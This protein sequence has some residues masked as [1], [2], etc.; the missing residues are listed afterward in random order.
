MKEKLKNAV[1]KVKTHLKENKELYIVGGCVLTA[2]AI[3][4]TTLSKHVSVSP[5]AIVIGGN[6]VVDQSTVINVVRNGHP[7]KALL[8]PMTGV[9][10]PSINS[11]AKAFDVS[12][13]TIRARISDG[14]LLHLGDALPA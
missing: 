1:T 10:Y 11:A 9:Q 6:N 8:D 5:N 2:G 12:T 4:G 3:A 7:G 13:S 14:T